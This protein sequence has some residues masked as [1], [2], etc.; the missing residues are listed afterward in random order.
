M[1]LWEILEYGLLGAFL[2]DWERVSRTR[3]IKRIDLHRIKLQKNFMVLESSNTTVTKFLRRIHTH[4]FNF[5]TQIYKFWWKFL[6]RGS[7]SKIWHWNFYK[8]LKLNKF[9]LHWNHFRRKYSSFPS[10]TVNISAILFWSI[11]DCFGKISFLE[12]ILSYWKYLFSINETIFLIGNPVETQFR[13]VR[14][15]TISFSMWRLKLFDI[16]TNIFNLR[17]LDRGDYFWGTDFWSQ[18]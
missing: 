6:W 14:M 8:G 10:W 5:W 2:G 18:N 16:R 4:F 1:R 17:A 11:F 15:L 9:I 3:I 12:S 7:Y 13:V